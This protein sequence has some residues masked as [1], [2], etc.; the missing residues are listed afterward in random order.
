MPRYVPKTYN[1]RSVLR[2]IIGAF[3]TLVLFVFILFLVLFFSLSRYVVD[4]QLELSWLDDP[5]PVTTIA[6][7]SD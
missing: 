3:I 5:P 4:G 6:P 7:D 2:V 1:N